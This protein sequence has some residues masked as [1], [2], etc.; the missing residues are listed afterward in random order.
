MANVTADAKKAILKTIES[1]NNLSASIRYPMPEAMQTE[2]Q[3]N[4]NIAVVF[5]GFMNPRK[6]GSV[7]YSIPKIISMGK[8]SRNCT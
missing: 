2:M 6:D 5:L 7:L 4:E 1:G 8:S 3:T